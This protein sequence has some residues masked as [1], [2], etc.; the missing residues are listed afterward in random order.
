MAKNTP[1]KQDIMNRL[2]Q[3]GIEYDSSN[4]KDVLQSLLE[5]SVEEPEVKKPVNRKRRVDN[6]DTHQVDIDI[7]A[8]KEAL[9]EEKYTK[10]LSKS[11]YDWY[12]CQAR[13]ATNEHGVCRKGK[14][15]PL[16]KDEV[17][18]LGNITVN[19]KDRGGRTVTESRP[20]FRKERPEVMKKR[21]EQEAEFDANDFVG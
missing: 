10:L 14:Y 18:R 3:L 8:A 13:T 4:R 16:H 9:K 1:T 2:D 12:Y 19:V 5:G 15:Y 7:R 21:L 6:R 11:G 20:R 17:E